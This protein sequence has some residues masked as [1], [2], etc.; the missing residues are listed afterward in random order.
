MDKCA[1]CFMMVNQQ[2]NDLKC[3]LSYYFSLKFFQLLVQG[4]NKYYTKL[5]TWV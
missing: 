3:G 1:E 2:L 4:R 5:Y